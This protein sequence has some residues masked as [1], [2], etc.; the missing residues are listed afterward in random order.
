MYAY[1]GLSQLCLHK[2]AFFLYIGESISMCSIYLCVHVYVCVYMCVHV[3]VHVCTRVYMCVCVCLHRSQRRMFGIFLC[4]ALPYSLETE[5]LTE[6]GARLVT[7]KP[8]S[9]SCLCPTS[10]A[11]GLQK[12]MTMC[13]FYFYCFAL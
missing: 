4:P 5:S 3:C 8:Q 10:V 13:R 12:H 9:S 6:P 11:L 2:I 7:S 1:S